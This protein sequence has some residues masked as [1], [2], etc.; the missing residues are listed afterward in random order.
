MKTIELTVFTVITFA[1]YVSYLYYM[2]SQDANP[3]PSNLFYAVGG[4]FDEFLFN[5]GV[6][7]KEEIMDAPGKVEKYLG[8]E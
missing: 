8:L 3:K 7:P 6:K 2:M 1:G 4:F 5:N